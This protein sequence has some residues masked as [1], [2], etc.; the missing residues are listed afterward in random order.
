[1]M[2]LFTISRLGFYFFNKGLFAP[3]GLGRFLNI[4]TGGL[5]FDLS[6]ILYTNLLFLLLFLIPQPF[7]YH[8][9][10][11]SI[12]KYLYYVTNSIILAVNCSDFIFYRFTLRRTTFKIFGEFEN[13]TNGFALLFEFI[14][15]YW[16][17][18]LFWLFLVALMIYLFKK[19]KIE[20][21]AFKNH[22][23]F[24]SS[25]LAMML[26]MVYLTIG[27]LRG[28]F[29]HS[30]RP[31]TLSNA[32]KYVEAPNQMA[33]V[34]NTPFAIFRTIGSSALPKVEYF[35]SK[36][37]LNE[38]YNPV[39]QA[40][41][42]TEF[43]YN[44]VV[45]IIMESFGREYVG[46]FNKH[47]D[48]GTY[49][50]YTPFLDSLMQNGKTFW[51]T[52]ANGRKSIDVLPS[53]LTSIPSVKTPFVL[54]HYSGNDL[55]SIASL[56][57]KKGYHTSFFHGA[58]NGSMGLQSF[59]NLIGFDN[60]YGRTEYGLDKEWD[61]IWGVWD[62]DYLPYFAKTLSTFKEPFVSALFSVSSHHPYKIPEKFEGKFPK[63]TKSI[64]Q[65]IHYSDYSL[66]LFFEEAKKHSW[67]DSTLFVI[68]ADHASVKIAYPEYK[69]IKGYFSVPILFYH[70]S[71]DL[72]SLDYDLAQQI[73]I[74]PSILSYL[75]YDEPYVAFGQDLFNGNKD[76]IAVNVLNDV[77]QLYM[78]D[79][80]IQYNESEI[81]S[82]YEFKKDSMFL[83]NIKGTMP[84]V[85]EKMLKMVQAFIQEFNGRMN[86]NELSFDK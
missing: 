21:P 5:K 25:G 39:F 72:T 10:F 9:I 71:D 61:G 27:G 66:K 49:Q 73:D 48:N 58:P 54:S 83:N 78:D 84:E 62:H 85:E 20:K 41:T 15:D 59:V 86:D 37:E 26:L 28:G 64:H 33:I 65:C 40:N 35:S 24:Y 11:Q 29:R 81:L 23:F 34:L 1:M 74:M 30:T 17:A 44:N 79:Y 82:L 2:L 60:Y 19:V 67:Y 18:V 63:G 80:L 14:L 50:G 56:L 55:N 22:L 75:N 52:I 43:K 57:K 46:F 68:T 32:G 53:V 47:L 76:R 8:K 45:I 42:N 70:P 3:I 51:H 38:I 6:A 31:I 36:E 13:E 12:L 16:Y 69:T 77:Y 4:M 7:R